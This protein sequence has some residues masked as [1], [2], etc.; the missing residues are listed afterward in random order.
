MQLLLEPDFVWR[1][2][3]GANIQGF[4]ASAHDEVNQKIQGLINRTR[5]HE[6]F[7]TAI[8][9][10]AVPVILERAEF[11]KSNVLV[12]DRV[13]LNGAAGIRALTQY[14]KANRYETIDLEARLFSYFQRKREENRQREIPLYSGLLEPD[15]PFVIEC[16]NTFNYFHFMTESLSQLCLLDGLD[17]Q[18]EIY[19]HY[20]NPDDKRQ[21]FTEKFVE[22]LFP[23][24]AGRVHFERAPKEYTRVLT[25]FDLLGSAG[26]APETMFE[27]L[28]EHLPEKVIVRGG[29]SNPN[30]HSIFLANGVGAPLLALR[31]RALRAIEG[32]DFSHLPK[33]FFI[34]RDDRTARTRRM[35]GED[36]LFEHLAL[37]DFEYVVFENLHP[38][39]QIAA[40]AGAEMVVGYHGAGFTNMLFANPE[41]C[42]IELGTLQT[43]QIRWGDFWPH[44]HA[45][46]C[47][48][49]N[50]FCDHA[51]KDP[52]SEPNFRKDGLVPVALSEKA[53]GQV[54]AFI[55]TMLGE[56]PKLKSALL[57]TDL[58]RQMLQAGAPERV[59]AL[60]DAH[61][62]IQVRHGELCLLMADACKALDRP[63]EELVALDQ[64]YK[65]N[66]QR[67]QTLVRIIWCANRCER[68]QVIRWALARLQMNFPERHAAFVS[69]HAWV[70]HVA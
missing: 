39:E 26:Q 17:F 47:T 53:V 35:E 7:K 21:P 49:V 37:F 48:Y 63:T 25:A 65:A 9:Y 34:G 61:K 1:P 57:L 29:A 59:I 36:L 50:F 3:E 67:W 69:N 51:A 58:A 30:Q 22:V 2:I 54:M 27:G 70:R 20:P 16:R 46:G 6:T 42:V 31:E 52:L 33:R 14:R 38:L 18:G 11:R 44:A 32:K 60:L 43:A 62:D 5:R 55:V 56:L 15:L 19:F 24:F 4:A 40:M 13:L 23:E 41:T 45:G 66:P 8:E 10:G 64:A 12:R 28:D 68:P